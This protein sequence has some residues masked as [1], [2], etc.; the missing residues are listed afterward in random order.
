MKVIV[1]EPRI[2]IIAGR[3]LLPGVN[4]VD[5]KQAVEIQNHP[6]TQKW[7]SMGKITIDQASNLTP[8]AVKLMGDMEELFK[9][10]KGQ[11]KALAQAANARIKE[12]NAYE[13]KSKSKGEKV[14]E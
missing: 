3:V 1:N 6:I 2:L 12:I 5:G 11:D 10:T 4:L 7:V 8:E 9:L 13:K 14:S